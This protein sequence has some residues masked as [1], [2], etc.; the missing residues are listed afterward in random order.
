MKKPDLR[1]TKWLAHI[2][3]EVLSGC[4][5][6]P[7]VS[8]RASRPSSIRTA[9]PYTRSKDGRRHREPKEIPRVLSAGEPDIPR[10][11]ARSCSPETALLPPISAPWPTQAQAVDASR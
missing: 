4:T 2:P 5:A 7:A 8:F 11:G 9:R 1:V 10:S 6:C 3:V